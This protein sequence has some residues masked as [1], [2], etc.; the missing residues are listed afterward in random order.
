MSMNS[1]KMPLMAVTIGVLA[2]FLAVA[3]VACGRPAATSTPKPTVT[4]TLEP[5]ATPVPAQFFLEILSPV[6]ESVVQTASMEVKGRTVPDAVVS[7]NG[8]SVDVNASGDFSVALT[9]EDG[10]NPIE[11]IASDF[12][13]HQESRVITV[14]YISQ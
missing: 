7:V 6:N 5:T 8:R 13:G 4:P 10:P 1:M 3:T 2:L 9:L 14:I 12:Q 11:V